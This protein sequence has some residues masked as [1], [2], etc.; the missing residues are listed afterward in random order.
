MKV[1]EG[2]LSSAWERQSFYCKDMRLEVKR[3]PYY[4]AQWLCHLNG[5]SNKQTEEA[6]DKLFIA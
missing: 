3:W 6:Q 4:P 2:G 5:L 1:Q